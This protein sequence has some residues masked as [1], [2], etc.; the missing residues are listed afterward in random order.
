MDT[1][2]KQRKKTASFLKRLRSIQHPNNAI[3]LMFP[4]KTY[5]LCPLA[6]AKFPYKNSFCRRF[7]P[8]TPH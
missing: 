3:I 2:L 1:V 6:A 4:F 7:L 5:I 8:G